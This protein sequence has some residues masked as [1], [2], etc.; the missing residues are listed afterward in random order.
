MMLLSFVGLVILSILMSFLSYKAIS[1]QY[2]VYVES[3]SRDV[4]TILNMQDDKI[5]YLN[6]I[7]T[8]ERITVIDSNGVVVFDNF[9][10]V[11]KL[12]N[13]KDRPEVSS[14]Y[15]NGYGEDKRFSKTT[16]KET[17]YYAVKLDNGE[18]CR[19]SITRNIILNIVIGNIAITI[20]I[21]VVIMFLSNFFALSITNKILEPFDKLG[22]ND[23]YD[24]FYEELT[25]YVNKIK[26]QKRELTSQINNIKYQNDTITI[27]TDNMQEGV[28]LLDDKN[29]V[30]T[31]NESIC[32]ILDIKNNSIIGENVLNVFDNTEL[33]KS[34]NDLSSLNESSVSVFRLKKDTKTYSVRVSPVYRN[35]KI[36]GVVILFVDITKSEVLDKYRREFSANVSHELKT[37]LMSI[38]GYSELLESG[39]VKDDDITRFASKIKN[40]SVKM[41]DLVEDILLI[42]E[43]DESVGK[44]VNDETFSLED[45]GQIVNETIIRL[46]DFANKKNI[47]INYDYKEIYY[48]VNKRLFEELINNLIYNAIAY[49]VD[50]GKIIVEFF[51]LDG[52]LVLKVKDTGIGIA[53]GDQEHIFERFYRVEKSRSRKNGG[54]GLGLAIVKNVAIY[55]GGTVSVDSVVGVG[56]TFT[57]VI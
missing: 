5:G 3:K 10:D 26:E 6:T 43:L 55:H 28:I 50:N 51:V 42:S 11:T 53:K 7:N 19:V 23:N 16:A 46:Q 36:K 21:L 22:V 45:V 31:Y 44:F 17:Y 12:E 41:S 8:D 27:I 56:S 57:V 40:E 13:H 4:A 33:T 34:L 54:T 32:E 25:P 38:Q 52:K 29:N 48:N 30:L 49:N 18:V 47:D 9:F 14:A 39:L 1:E 15:T 35:T 37:P 20:I 24:A 2:K